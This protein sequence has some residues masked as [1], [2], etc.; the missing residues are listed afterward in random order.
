VSP[1]RGQGDG[2]HTDTRTTRANSIPSPSLSFKPSPPAAVAAAF[3]WIANTLV[4]LYFRDVNN[5]L[6]NLSFL[7]FCGW[8]AGAFVF[9][10][11]YVPETKGKTPAELLRWFNKGYAPTGG[12]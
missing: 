5:L 7:P 2:S 6:G 3:N 10:I 1:Q 9:T 4:A 8:L 11:V 12:E